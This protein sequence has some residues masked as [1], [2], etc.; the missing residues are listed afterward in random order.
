MDLLSTVDLS[1]LFIVTVFAFIAGF[2][3]AVVGGGGLLQLPVLLIQ[4]P[5]T[6]LATLFGTNK[7]AAFLGTCTAAIQYSKRV[8]FDIVL[9]ISIGLWAALSS[10]LG[11]RMVNFVDV[12]LFKPFILG[13]LIFI[14]IY[15]LFKKDLG[16]ATSRMV[17]KSHK[18]V[19]G[20]VLAMVLGFY[21]GFFG[22]GTGSFFVLGF[23]MLLGFDFLHASAYAKV[24]NSITNSAALFVFLSQGN[25]M[26]SIAL[27]M[28]FANIIGNIV[29]TNTAFKKGN[30]FIRMVFLVVVFLLIVRYAY[31][32]IH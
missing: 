21:D 14:F 29:G 17:S 15:T 9:L 5:Q 19:Y 7:I 20:S 16:Q 30:S 13:I 12:S 6:A 1:T 8:K 22:P 24:I 23:V 11:A 18:I 4:F 10:Y 3:D 31:D 27:F 25:F 2:I 28:A 26:L 32:I